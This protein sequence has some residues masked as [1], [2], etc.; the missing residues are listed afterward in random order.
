M[1]VALTYG[2]GIF[3]TGVKRYA[4]HLL[5]ELLL[6]GVDAEQRALKRR[7]LRFG[8]RVLGG[9]VSVWG[10]RL[11]GRPTG[12]DVVHA[13]DPSV[14]A[15]GTDVVTIHDLV[16]EMFPG[17]YQT[18]LAAKIDQRILRT[19]AR[20]APFFL[21]DTEATRGEVISRWGVDPER[22]NVVHLGID[23][24][25]FRPVERPAPLAPGDK[26]TFVLVG[27]D[28]PRKNVRLA[29]ETIVALRAAHGIDARL[30]RLGAA[31][32]PAVSNEYRAIARDGK[33]DLAEPGGLSD[34][35]LIALLS[36][37]DALLWPSLAEGFGFPP[38]EA[39]AC[40]TPVVA[41]DTP[42]NREVCGPLTT[43][44]RNNATEAADAVA[45]VLRR[46]PTADALRAYASGFTWR[47][48]AEGTLA[49]YEAAHSH[50]KPL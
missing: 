39:M 38:L 21:A 35:D 22:V 37:A 43:Y 13:L 46:P 6:M 4:E 20:R 1:K 32:W 3:A 15:R 5:P 23:L 2:E 7:E 41:L 48:T 45:R 25:T 33:V 17:W 29:V 11:G 47:R 28:N 12:F 14:A 50:R 49:A 42:V 40:G 18:T 19:I 10:A 26:P 36:H 30:I 8:R 16:V 31:R 9:Y 24:K 44:H 34:E 27:D